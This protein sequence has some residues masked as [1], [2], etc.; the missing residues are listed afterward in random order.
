[1]WPFHC[2]IA[3]HVSGGLYF[4]LLERPDELQQNLDIP[5]IM[6]QTCRDWSAWT[7]TNVPDMIDSGL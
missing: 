3:W 2:H 5:G 6:T 7:G 1:M 4:Q